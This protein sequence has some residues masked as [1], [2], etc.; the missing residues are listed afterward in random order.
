MKGTT[1]IT[2]T[3]CHDTRFVIGRGGSFIMFVSSFVTYKLDGAAKRITNNMSASSIGPTPESGDTTNPRTRIA[4]SFVCQ[5]CGK[6]FKS[7][8]ELNLHK[9]LDHQPSSLDNDKK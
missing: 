3:D 7:D 2:P 9:S 5:L 8:N 4:Q 6:S 1:A